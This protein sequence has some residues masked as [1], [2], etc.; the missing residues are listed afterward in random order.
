MKNNIRIISLN[1]RIAK[2]AEQH[3]QGIREPRI[4]EFIADQSPNTLG[5]QES[6]DFWRDR[7]DLVLAGYKR[8]QD[9]PAPEHFKNYVYYNTNTTELVEGGRFWLSDT[10]DVASK[11]FGS[12]FFI[13]CG[14]GIFKDK[15][16]GAEFAHMNT[17]L[18]V[19]SEETRKAEIEVLLGRAKAL[20]EKYPVLITG[21]FNSREESII[22]ESLTNCG[23]L[24]DF[25]TGLPSP[26][27]T[28]TFN[29][30][31]SE[32]EEP[33]K[34]LLIDFGF[35]NNKINP[36]KYNIIDKWAGGYMSDHNALIFDFTI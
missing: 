18:D 1:L 20:A 23:F 7:L 6:S 12:R 9:S 22:Y 25:K 33:Q 32:D 15:K 36:E 31:E 17:H 35:C 34:H 27:I 5:V 4:A 11:A 19:F 24:A 10:P 29:G 3:N 16:S 8:A 2:N 14:W 28:Y 30:Y 26:D 21:D 13:S